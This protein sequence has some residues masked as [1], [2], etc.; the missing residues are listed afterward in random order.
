MYELLEPST[1]SLLTRRHPLTGRCSDTH[2]LAGQLVRYAPAS[3]RTGTDCRE[4]FRYR[5]HEVV[6]SNRYA[7]T[8]VIV[9]GR[10]VAWR[11][12]HHAV[13][14]PGSPAA[15]SATPGVRGAV[16]R[17]PGSA[18]RSRRHKRKGSRR[19][20]RAVGAT[21]RRLQRTGGPSARSRGGV[22]ATGQGA[23]G[24]GTSRGAAARGHYRPPPP[25][26]AREQ[27]SSAPGAFSRFLLSPVPRS[28]TTSR[29]A[30]LRSGSRRRPPAGSSRGRSVRPRRR[31]ALPRRRRPSPSRGKPSRPG[32]S[33]LRPSDTA[34]PL[35][36]H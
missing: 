13:R 21:G 24:A 15:H 33:S 14:R 7:V 9:N 10:G 27:Q 20:P 25:P 29:P 35:Q 23:G 31:A 36:S 4:L 19:L 30:T 34:A 1:A 12:G 17:K 2:Q 5:P 3:R 32:R 28:S 26:A 8:T 11:R 16:G 6:R 22:A 18:M